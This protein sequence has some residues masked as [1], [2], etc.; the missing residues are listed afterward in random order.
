ME[1]K[2]YHKKE[3]RFKIGDV[4]AIREDEKNRA[5]WKTGNVETDHWKK[6]RC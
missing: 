2:E 6:Q 4:V 5:Y 3:M 1:K